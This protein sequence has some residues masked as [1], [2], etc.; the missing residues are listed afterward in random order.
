[1]TGYDCLLNILLI[2]LKSKVK[3]INWV[4]KENNFFSAL[5]A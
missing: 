5:S 2:I 1:M 4:W 3:E